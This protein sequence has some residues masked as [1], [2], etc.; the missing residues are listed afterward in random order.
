MEPSTEPATEPSGEP[1]TEETDT[2]DTNDTQDT[3]DTNDTGTALYDLDRGLEADPNAD[4]GRRITTGWHVV[5]DGTFA[6]KTTIPSSSPSAGI[7]DFLK[8]WGVGMSIGASNSE[9]FEHMFGGVG[10][11]AYELPLF[12]AR[13]RVVSIHFQDVPQSESTLTGCTKEVRPSMTVRRLDSDTAVCQE[14]MEQSQTSICLEAAG[15]YNGDIVN[16][17]ERGFQVFVY[18]ALTTGSTEYEVNAYLNS[19][20]LSSPIQ[21]FQSNLTSMEQANC[22]GTITTTDV[23]FYIGKGHIFEAQDNGGGGSIPQISVFN[24]EGRIDNIVLFTPAIGSSFYMTP[25]LLDDFW[26]DTSLP[27]YGLETYSNVDLMPNNPNKD[28]F[29]WW[30][31]EQPRNANNEP[32]GLSQ[33]NPSLVYDLSPERNQAVPPL[34]FVEGHGAFAIGLSDPSSKYSNDNNNLLDSDFSNWSCDGNPENCN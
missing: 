30:G 16:F 10:V 8:P 21:I 3:Q 20:G 28:G 22:T 15:S 18:S 5:M 13:H 1:S 19:P 33:V 23:D 2:Q 9:V 6:L 24:L 11:F 14:V 7:L 17:Q 4:Y 27:F 31:F 34:E 29:T 25:A 32:L 12:E 26:L